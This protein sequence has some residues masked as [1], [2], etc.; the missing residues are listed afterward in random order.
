MGIRPVHDDYIKDS[1]MCG[2][3][4]TINLGN[5]GWPSDKPLPG[6]DTEEQAVLNQAAANGAEYLKGE[7]GVTFPE[8]LLPFQHSV[9]QAT[10]IEWVNSEYSNP[11]TA[12]SCQ[13][14]HMKNSFET[15]DGSVKVDAIT[16]QIATIQDATL[17]EVANLLP[18]EEVT[19]PFREGYKR[20]AFVGLNAYMV[21]MMCQFRND[22]G[23]SRTD[24]MTY[25]TNGAQQSIDEMALQ[26]R[27][28][29]SDVSISVAESENGLT[30][31]V[32]V[33]N[34][35]G[36][37]MP[38][39]VGFRRAFLEVKA[40]NDRGDV[41]W[42][43]GCSNDVGVILGP[44]G[45]PLKTEFLDYVPEGAD[46]AL[47]QP[48]HRTITKQTQVQIYEELTQD[49]DRKFTTSFIHRIYHAK[50]NRLIPN[51]WLKPGSDAFKKKF[52]N[53]QVTS[54]FLKATS[55]EHGAAEDPDFGPGGDLTR[56]EITLPNGVVPGSVTVTATLM[57]QAIPPYYLKQRFETA[58]D[59]P[60]TQRLYYLASRLQTRGTLIEGWKIRINSASG[61]AG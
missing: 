3:C 58:P 13:D 57:Y 42:C 1:E 18:L 41:I 4:H 49:A 29:T 59:G 15:P 9:E 52:G 53:S 22:M 35:T 12:Q 34:K 30:A 45:K 2:A 16:T 6:V 24:P 19:V 21:E 48:H 28:Q 43:S 26:A 8:K 17:P 61:K 10:Y 40:T 46:Q 38:S 47:F 44:D 60:A 25:A 5:V 37:R 56:Y 50:D 20:H 39:G 7:Y 31:T 11:D 32:G 23:L 27:D 33:T 55:P 36:H 54:A 51:G 14:C